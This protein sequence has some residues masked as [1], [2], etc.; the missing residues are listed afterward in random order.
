MDTKEL[1]SRFKW[2]FVGVVSV[3]VTAASVYTAAASFNFVIDRPAWHSEL[4]ERTGYSLKR[5][6]SHKKREKLNV[7]TH[8]KTLEDKGVVVPTWVREKKRDIDNDLKKIER[9]LEKKR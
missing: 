2:A 1:W 5:E 8:I 4:L 3:I 9:L 6:R 7:D